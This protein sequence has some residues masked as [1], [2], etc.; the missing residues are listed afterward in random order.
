MLFNGLYLLA[1]F[2]LSPWIIYRSWK[3]N[4]YRTGWTE[5]WLGQVPR[6]VLNSPQGSERGPQIFWLHAVSVGEVQVLKTLIDAILAEWPDAQIAISTTT[7]TGMELA[8]RNYA[9]HHVFYMP[10]DFTWA[11]RQAFARIKPDWLLLAELEI[12]PNLLNQAVLARCQ[13][14]VINGRL[15]ENS[16]KGYRRLRWLLKPSFEKIAFVGAQDEDY[17]QRFVAMGVDQSRTHVTGS[18]KF[19]GA[20]TDRSHPEIAKRRQEL[21]LHEGD[22]VWVAG[23]TQHPEE[24]L[25]MKTFNSI[26]KLDRFSRLRLILVPR[27]PERGD[28]IAQHIATTG[29]RLIQ[30][31]KSRHELSSL[32]G[33]HQAKTAEQQRFSDWDVLLADTI[34]ELR[35]WWGM[36]TIAFVGGSFGSRGGQNMIEP[37]AYGAPTAVGPNTV[38]FKDVMRIFTDANAIKTLE[39]PSELEPWII[40]MLDNQSLR[41]SVGQRGIAVASQHRGATSR[42]IDLLTRYSVHNLSQKIIS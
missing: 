38:N 26:R 19:D 27:H 14:A 16:F 22:L 36:A 9:N 20:N 28:D 31:S 39:S 12:W 17:A 34:G 21:N 40:E 4:R 23:S 37:V 5:K 1:L 15:S 18:L 25:I 42:T 35:W 10:L 7:Q 3:T 13:V 2:L 33:D 29:F 41:A 30:R 32:N 24:E 6:V 11:V 8:K